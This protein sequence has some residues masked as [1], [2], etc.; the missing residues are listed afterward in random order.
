MKKW[1]VYV[2][3]IKIYLIGSGIVVSTNRGCHLDNRYI[4]AYTAIGNKPQKND[5]IVT[6]KNDGIKTCI[7]AKRKNLRKTHC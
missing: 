1:T 7:I 4:L 2:S 5:V 6:I 3:K